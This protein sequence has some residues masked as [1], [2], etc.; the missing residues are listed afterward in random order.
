VPVLERSLN[1]IVRR[2]ESLRTTFQAVDGEPWQVIAP[3]LQLP[4]PVMDL[5][6]L[7]AAQRQAEAL[8]LATEEARQPFDLAAGPLVRAT[9]LRME[10]EAYVFLLTMHHIVADGW[11]MGVFWEE[12]TAV[13]E[14]FEQGQPSPLPELSIQ[15]ADFA[16]WQR[17]WLQGEVGEAQLAFWKK[18]LAD[19]PVTQFPT[20]WPRPEAPTFQGAHYPFWIPASLHGALKKLSQE[21]G[22]TLFMTLLAAFQVLLSR[23]TDQDDI[24]VGSPIANRNRSE[25]EG[26]IGFFVNSLILRTDLSGNPTFPELLQRVREV[27][28]AAYAHQDLPFEKLVQEL[29]PERDIGRNP[30]F[31]VSFQLFS[32]VNQTSSASSSGDEPLEIERG[33]ANIDFAL[34]LWEYEDGIYGSVEYSTELF[35]AETVGRIT[36]HYLALLRGIASKPH[37]HLAEFP[38]LNTAERRKLLVD[39]NRTSRPYDQA[40]C[41]HQLFEAQ[42]KRTPQGVALRLEAEELTYEELNQRANLLAEHLVI[43]G[44]GPEVLVGVC[45][46]RSFEMIVALLGVLKAGAAYVPFDPAY[47]TERLSLMLDDAQPAI[48]ITQKKFERAL[49]AY[50]GPIVR[51]DTEPL[52]SRAGKTRPHSDVQSTNLAYVIY[53]SGSTGK[54][55]GVMVSH[56]AVCNH[57]LWMQT[58]FPLGQQDRVPQKYSI[59]F[60]AS[61]LEIFGPLIAG[62]TLVLTSPTKHFDAGEFVRFL[63]EEKITVLDLVPSLL[64]VLIEEERFRECRWLRRVICGGEVLSHNLQERFFKFADAELTNAYGPTEAT[65]GAT[66]WTCRRRNPTGIVPIGRP[67]ANTQIYLLDR[68]M[69]PVPIGAPGEIY[70][71]GDGLARGYWNHP[72]LTQEKFIPNPFSIEPG[73]RL[74]KTG[75]RAR[76]LP[77]GDLEYL[78]RMDEQVKVRGF[79]IE[80]GEIEAALSGHPSVDACAVV[81]REDVPDQPRLVAYVVP[82]KNTP[83]MFPSVGEYS[84]YDELMYY[85]MT[86]DERR[87]ASYKVAI[88]RLVP[89]KVVVDIGTGADAILARFCAEAGAERVYA[90][91][92]REEAYERARDLVTSLHLEDKIQVLHG[93]STKIQLP[94]PVDVC[95]SELLGT[96]GSSEGAP[97]ILNNARRFLKQHGVMIPARCVTHIAAVQLP[98]EI[99]GKPELTEAARMYVEQVFQQMGGPFDLRLCIRNFPKANLI[100]DTAVFEDLDFRRYIQPESTSYVQLRVTRK[101]RLDGLLLWLKV[102]TLEDECIDVLDEQMNWLP[103][104]FPLFHPGIRV[105][106]GDAI[107]AE[108]A[109]KLTHPVAPDY[110]LKGRVIGNSGRE[111]AFEFRS[112]YPPTSFQANPFYEALFDGTANQVSGNARVS[113]GGAEQVSRWREIYEEVYR[114]PNMTED[115]TFNIVGWNSSYTGQPIPVD[116]M[117]EQVEQTVERILRLQ[118]RHVLEIGCGP[119]LMLFRIAPHCSYYVGTD[120]SA[121]AL[122]YVRDQL[123][124]LGL[125]HVELLERSAVD[126]TELKD[127]SFDVVILNSVV[128][129]FPSIEY[130]VQVLEGVVRV[131]SRGGYIFLG[132]IRSLPL[133]ETFYASLELHRL[134]AGQ[135]L[136]ELRE[137]VERR[138]SQEDELVIDPRFFSALQSYLPQITAV[139]LQLK[140]GWSHN[141]LTRFRYD[142][143][144]QINGDLLPPLYPLWRDWQEVSSV[145]VLRQWI[146]SNPAEVL[147]IRRVPNARLQEQ[148]KNLSLIKSQDSSRTIEQVKESLGLDE[149]G[150]EPEE[151]WQLGND[152]GRE[153]NLA[154]SGSGS[155]GLYDVLVRRRDGGPVP[156]VIHFGVSDAPDSRR[157]SSYAT[158]PLQGHRAQKLVPALSSFLKTQLPEHMVPS[159]FVMLDNLPRTPSGKLDRRALPAPELVRPAL[160]DSFVAP[161]NDAEEQLARIWRELFHVRQVGVHDNFFMQLGGHSLLATQLVS[162]VREFFQIELPL[163]RLFELPT[164]AELAVVVEE[165]L[166]ES[167]ERLSED[168]VQRLLGEHM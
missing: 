26:L 52:F 69:N 25:L 161:R 77:D 78:G 72:E 30:L 73:T 89:G 54:P 53:T 14:A 88:Q 75:D 156:S 122:D 133:L 21:G 27:A 99:A 102:Y 28:L 159:S 64:Q 65:I 166:V 80:P 1:E 98:D 153:I 59:S 9:L 83:E 142:V 58:A 47:P 154:W 46:E 139:E 49:K 87:N 7:P 105:E 114:Q 128:Q 103:V 24:V 67:I 60:D 39:W 141:E 126:F 91:E 45:L 144:L 19:L 151:F 38:I 94:E 137:W 4:L 143:C 150:V 155:E 3:S 113:S 111:T 115:P 164:I 31:Q 17:Q 12:L 33:T 136:R 167:I 36:K 162:R 61:V 112:D 131:L 92:V 95:V 106:S 124:R 146:Q 15:Y 44:I 63:A 97:V 32:S 10:E 101:S 37:C 129:Y 119:G 35:E 74:Y 157:W 123:P 70:I 43:H 79:R 160:E 86:H 40:A 81:S 134:P 163:V 96:I 29:Q 84:V 56:Q 116:E 22:V 34:D 20:D 158:D 6:T 13:W 104:F 145:T 11:S 18:Q 125:S 127:E 85:A 68:H 147:G 66:S 57:L 16:V 138:K 50:R 5:R 62:A 71:G 165:L 130:L 41:V 140:R 168:T 117:R 132:D 109:S 23:Y 152:L 149:S 108:C 93:D 82:S 120:F 121:E 110:R 135:S 8:R 100:S 107:T 51:L 148:V 90:I 76:Y 2:H 48:L 118:P 42:A 55:R